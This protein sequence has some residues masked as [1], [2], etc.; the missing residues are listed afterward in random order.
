MDT[1][2]NQLNSKVEFITALLRSL[3]DPATI[4]SLKR[5]IDNLQQ[6]SRTLASNNERLGSIIAEAEQ[7]SGQLTPLLENGNRTVQVMQTQILPEAYKALTNLNALATS[8]GVAADKI[9]QDPSILIRG[10]IPVRPGP[11]E[12]R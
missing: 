7:A 8:L 2:L 10:S 5:S 9:S 12:T 6:V 3:L 11:G 4:T 1:T